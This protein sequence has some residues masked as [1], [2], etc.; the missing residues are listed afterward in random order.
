[1]KSEGHSKVLEDAHG[2]LVEFPV[3]MLVD[4]AAIGVVPS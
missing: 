1:V 2:R 3:G 4:E